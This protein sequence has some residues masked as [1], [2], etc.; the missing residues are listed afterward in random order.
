MPCGKSITKITKFCIEARTIKEF[1]I[2]CKLLIY[3]LLKKK[4]VLTHPAFHS[5]KLNPNYTIY[6]ISSIP[7]DSDS[8]LLSRRLAACL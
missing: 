4:G 1:T 2:S 6:I 7:L 5:I 8:P 3:I